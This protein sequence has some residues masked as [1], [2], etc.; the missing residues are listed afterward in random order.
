M[1][2]FTLLC[3]VLFVLAST[4]MTCKNS[5]T[6]P[7]KNCPEKPKSSSRNF[8]WRTDT[9]GKAGSSVGDVWVVN[10]NDIY[11]GG[12]FY[13]KDFD[14][15]DH[16]NLAHWNGKKWEMKR[17]YFIRTFDQGIDSSANRI[18]SIRYFNKDNIVA[19]DDAGLSVWNGFE[20]LTFDSP[21][22][23]LKGG[24]QKVYGTSSTNLFFGGT[25][26]TQSIGSLTH[27]DGENFENIE[28]GIS[29]PVQDVFGRGDTVFLVA[30][31]YDFFTGEIHKLNPVTK[32]LTRYNESGLEK[33]YR[34]IWF[35]GDTL[36]CGNYAKLAK[37]SF[38]DTTWKQIP[39]PWQSKAVRSIFG[40]GYNDIMVV[41]GFALIAHYNGENWKEYLADEVG[42]KT[43]GNYFAIKGNGNC[44]AMAGA[45]SSFAY[46]TLAFRK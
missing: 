17:I 27:F 14:Q 6:E 41:G 26:A 32:Q 35:W 42:R 19:S 37:K 18:N 9:L 12:E 44:F 23:F 21:R 45:S 24:L 29:L 28:T 40:N 25:N 31:N 16:Y 22:D 5:P 30:S 13:I 1:K 34:S 15:Y 36:Y 20:W 8:T 46:I 4:A 39:I 10:E 7:E 3:S 33:P 11:V 2:N 38:S 43:A